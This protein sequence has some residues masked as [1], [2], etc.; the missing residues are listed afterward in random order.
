MGA[1]ACGGEA[2][3]ISGGPAGPAVKVN[4]FCG[5]ECDADLLRSDSP[6][7]AAEKSVESPKGVELKSPVPPNDVPPPGAP[8]PNALPPLESKEDWF[9]GM[10]I[11]T[12]PTEGPPKEPVVARPF[13]SDGVPK[14][15]ALA[16]VFG[17]G[18]DPG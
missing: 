1:W 14:R 15:F 2:A 3:R 11:P 16:F 8:A 17:I 18:V 9:L 10:R 12:L 6:R 5:M 4:W 7:G 13:P